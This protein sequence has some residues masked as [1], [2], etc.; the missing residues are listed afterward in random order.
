M[1]ALTPVLELFQRRAKILACDNAA[2]SP[3]ET[4]QVSIRQRRASVSASIVSA[5]AETLL[6]MT[7]GGVRSPATGVHR[8]DQ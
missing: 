5:A 8:I 1:P 6:A 4:H 3:G 7:A 2:V